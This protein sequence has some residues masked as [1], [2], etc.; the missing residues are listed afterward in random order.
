M[1]VWYALVVGL[2]FWLAGWALGLK[3]F[4][5]FMGTV[6]L[7]LAAAGYEIAKPYL[8]KQLGRD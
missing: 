2:A 3:A 4:D 5:T 1:A 6:A 8:R 7:V